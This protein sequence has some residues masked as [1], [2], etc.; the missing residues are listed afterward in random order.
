MHHNTYLSKYQKLNSK[1]KILKAEREK[2]QT[3][4]KGI[5]INILADFSAETL[6]V[7]GS[8]RIYLKWWKGK[9]NNQDNST[10][11]DLNQIQLR[12]QKFYRQA[13]AKRIQHYQT[14]FTKKHYKNLSRWETWE[15]KHKKEK[16]IQKETQTKLRKW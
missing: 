16:N 12:N 3:T 13:K 1:K 15:E 7:R 9:T 10:Q 6:Q 14:S 11:Q 4:Y 8:G 5:P 2:Q